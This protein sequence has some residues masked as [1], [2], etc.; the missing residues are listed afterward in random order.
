MRNGTCRNHYAESA[1]DLKKAENALIPKQKQVK[2]AV[3][4]RYG[5]GVK[6]NLLEETLKRKTEQ[7]AKSKGKTEVSP[8]SSSYKDTLQKQIDETFYD[9]S[10]L[11]AADQGV[12]EGVDKLNDVIK[13]T[14][15]P[16]I[17]KLDKTWEKFTGI[18][19]KLMMEALS[20]QDQYFHTKELQSE[21]DWPSQNSLA[22]RLYQSLWQTFGMNTERLERQSKQ[23]HWRIRQNYRHRRPDQPRPT[24]PPLPP[25][26][27][28][29]AVNVANISNKRPA[30]RHIV[31]N[32]R[33][34]AISE[35]CITSSKFRFTVPGFVNERR[36]VSRP[37]KIFEGRS[38]C[39][40]DQRSSERCLGR[41]ENNR[42]PEI[43]CQKFGGDMKRAEKIRS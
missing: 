21:L 27:Q 41:A 15:N 36:E 4:Q 5:M 37:R 9:A 16:K 11:S 29:L 33:L 43:V 18:R 42:R 3:E 30:I 7:D 2:E 10:D 23:T 26:R 39:E 22:V 13:R 40:G 28:I 35:I 20:M 14:K 24:A 25:S 32:T 8:G 1:N 12:K 17:S 31:R 6:L 38:D 34:W 19:K